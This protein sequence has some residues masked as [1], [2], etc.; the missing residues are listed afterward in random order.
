MESLHDINATAASSACREAVA[1]LQNGMTYEQL[2]AWR[3]DFRAWRWANLR[4]ITPRQAEALAT[5]APAEFWI[6][7]LGAAVKWDGASLVG[8]SLDGAWLNG[9]WLN[10]A[11]LVRAS[12]NGAYRPENDIPGWKANADG[13]LSR[14]EP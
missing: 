8:A 7:A 1:A 4:T 9:A 12:L 14:V 10:G 6:R 5:V 3:P 13:Y 11:S 2:Y